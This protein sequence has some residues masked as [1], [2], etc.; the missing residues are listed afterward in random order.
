V[1]I[2]NDI[3]EADLS[4]NALPLDLMIK[5]LPD[6]QVFLITTPAENMAF[7]EL[8]SPQIKTAVKERVAII[9]NVLS[10]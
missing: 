5:Y 10:L 3:G 8:P 2:Q 4:A 9:I 6:L 7:G 1:L